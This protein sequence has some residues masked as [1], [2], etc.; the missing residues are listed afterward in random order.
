MK[1]EGKVRLDVLLE[2]LPGIKNQVGSEILVG[3]ICRDSR[4]VEKDDLFVAV[5]GTKVDGSE[6]AA[7]AVRAGAAAVL[8]SRPLEGLGVPVAVAEDVRLV[9]GMAAARMYG[10]P[11][12]K[13]DII[14]VTGTNG[15]TTVTYLIES[16]L[17]SAGKKPAVIGTIEYRFGN[18]A[19]PADN[20]TPES[21][22]LIKIMEEVQREGATH[23]VME[24]SSHALDQKRVAGM[25]I[26]SA[27]FTNL[28]RDHLDYHADM[29]EYFE[30]KKKLFTEVILGKWAEVSEKD[31]P[32]PLAALNL[33]DPRGT[34]LA[35][36]MEKNATGYLGYG[37]TSAWAKVKAKN[38]D[39]SSGGI[40]ARIES[41]DAEFNIESRLVGEHNL[42]NILAAVSILIGRGISPET[43]RMGVRELKKVPGR[44][45]PV[46]NSSGVTV[47]VDYAHTPDALSHAVETC[48]GLARKRLITVFGCGGDRDP[49][50]RPEMGKIA[51]CGSN[52]TVVTSDNPRTEDPDKIIE[53]VMA[54]IRELAEKKDKDQGA[55]RRG[56]REDGPT[57]GERLVEPDRRKAIRAAIQ[58]AEP[59]DIVLIAGKGHEDYQIIGGEKTHFDDR[60]EARLALMEK[61]RK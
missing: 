15:K 7:V 52:L 17:K 14:G 29:D 4:R 40:K 3:G 1:M 16:I 60:E 27:V 2:G 23:V 10:R 42:E 22:D 11:D 30:A 56:K 36:E 5:P 37:L 26:R 54:G 45:E 31:G 19:W 20:T 57:P 12:L 39:I 61:E 18:K 8:A 48:R 55:V 44:L 59:G 43:I 25:K 51:V 33:D 24:I 47:L 41:G 35:L 21:M 34:A 49:G 53:D 9:M 32:E 58:A 13:L 50:K 28:S 46:E 6:F 38:V